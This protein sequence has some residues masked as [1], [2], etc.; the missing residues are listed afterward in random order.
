M[1]VFLLILRLGLTGVFGLAA[2]AKFYDPV[3]TEKALVGFGVPPAMARPMRWLLPAAEFAV[4]ALL[5]FTSTSWYGALGTAGLLAIFTLA[6]A[7]QIA[8]GNAPDCHCFGQVRSEPVGASSIVRNIVFLAAAG[9][10]LIQGRGLQG[11]SLINGSQDVLLLVIGAAVLV[12]ATFVLMSVRHISSQQSELMRSIEVM[13]LVA[14]EGS[15][16][17]ERD[18]GDPHDG[19]SIGAV[20]P[21]FEAGDLEGSRITLDDL[22]SPGMPLLLFFVSPNC[23]P[24]KG[25]VPEFEQW[26]DELGGKVDIAF[27][28]SGAAEDN[29]IK[30][31]EKI[32]AKMI[33]QERRDIGDQYQTRWTPT[34]VFIDRNGRI[35]SH[36]NAGDTAIRDL[37]ASIMSEDVGREFA[38][39]TNGNGHSYAPLRIGEPVPDLAVSDIRGREIRTDYFKDKPTLVAFWST[40]CPHCVN[41]ADELK[42]W[43]RSR[44]PDS[45]NLLV[46]SDAEDTSL[47]LDSP[48]VIDPGHQTAMAFGMAGTPSAV[49]VNENG[50]FMSE[51]AVGASGLWG[52]IGKR[53]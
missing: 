39:F 46:F 27:I 22:R 41:M 32:A 13:E 15:T 34:A 44:G 24:C 14:R 25:L 29:H 23:T 21:D 17:V 42:S 10:L 4:A 45:P 31:G 48:V 18:A 8:K 9:F 20:A 40:T 3:G 47:D 36:A 37:V 51:T 12:V 50:R 6:M 35:A 52:L 16:A 2:I 26:L 49:L 43:E 19:L 38:H 11:V 5:I 7:V 28:S 53:K 1:E 30:F 33:L